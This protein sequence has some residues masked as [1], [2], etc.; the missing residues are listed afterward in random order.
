MAPGGL[1][2]TVKIIPYGLPR[3]A[4]QAAAE[5]GR[6][7]LALA[8]IVI[9]AAE[10]IVTSHAAGSGEETGKGHGAIEARL[11]AL[12]MTLARVTVVAH[13]TGALAAAIA[14]ST[15]PMISFADAVFGSYVAVSF[16]AA[17]FTSAL[18][19]PGSLLTLRAMDAAQLAQLIPDTGI[20]ICFKSISDP[21]CFHHITCPG[22]LQS[23]CQWRGGRLF[24]DV[25]AGRI[26][27]PN[28]LHCRRRRLHRRQ[29]QNPIRSG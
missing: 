7:A 9:A 22:S 23:A 6:G 25:P 1:V 2:A 18:L 20:V 21:P 8:P 27:S 3:A 16:S 24:K 13:D 5:A 26:R 10:L 15:A 11:T 28:C 17:K 12:G 29:N 14:A 19:T 4:V